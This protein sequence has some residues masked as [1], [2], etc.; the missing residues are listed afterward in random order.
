MVLMHFQ[1]LQEFLDKSSQG[2]ILLTLGSMLRC[3]TLPKHVINA[4]V[5]TFSKLQYQVLWK[6]EDDL[7]NL[8]PNIIIKKWIPVK[9]ILGNLYDYV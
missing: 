1:D 2:V 5:N 8:P 6:I 9:D 7:P 4:F 3:S